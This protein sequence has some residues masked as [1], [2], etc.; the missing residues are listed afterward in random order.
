MA[1]NNIDS[2]FKFTLPDLGALKQAAQGANDFADAEER[3]AAAAARA[4]GPLQRLA[5]LQQQA[6]N[7][8]NQTGGISAMRA[9]DLQILIARAQA[10]ANRAT[11]AD[12]SFSK[13]AASFVRSTRFGGGGGLGGAMPLIGKSMDLFLGSQA[14]TALMEAAGPIALVATAAAAAAKALYDAAAQSAQLGKEF[15]ALGFATGG[16]T[17]ETAKLS[18]F[19]KVFGIDAGGAAQA[20]Q[21]RITSNP[22]AMSVAAAHGVYNLKAP[23]GN[24]DMATDLLKAIEAMRGMKTAEEKLRFARLLG[25]E[26]TLSLTQVSNAT[27]QSIK[28]DAAL[29]S[30]VMDQTFQRRAAEF[31]AQAGRLGQAAQNAGVSVTKPV[32]PIIS[33]ITDDITNYVNFFTTLSE[34]VQSIVEKIRA[35]PLGHLGIQAFMMLNPVA[36]ELNNFHTL[37]QFLKGMSPHASSDS[38]ATSGAAHINENSRELRNVSMGLA[39]L[40]KHLGIGGGERTR[41][42]TDRLPQGADNWRAAEHGANHFGYLG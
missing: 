26:S 2:Q 19:S 22:M 13:R 35:N 21:D 3:A 34:G 36:R 8:V 23:F 15:S 25:I 30:M 12:D 9:Q 7:E 28:D 10:S 31:N 38:G 6:F 40:N 29:T 14:S 1:D 4:V 5:A 17:G 11:G 33:H 16:N 39:Q 37:S 18:V 42:I 20:L 32:L 41:S 27:F 24:T